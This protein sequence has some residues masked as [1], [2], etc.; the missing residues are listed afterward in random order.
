MGA[1]IV[2]ITPV[3]HVIAEVAIINQITH[4]YSKERSKSKSPT[5]LLTYQ[6]TYRGLIS[7]C[8]FSE[9]EAK[10][11]EANYHELYE[12]SDQW[13]QDKLHQ[14]EKDG[15]VTLAF[16]LRLRTPILH[17]TLIGSTYTPFQAEKEA[18]TAG[19]AV[20]GQSYGLLNSRAGVDLQERVIASEHRLDIKTC[21]QIHDANYLL[22]R[23][24]LACLKWLNDNLVECVEWQELPEIQ[25]PEVKLTGNLGVFY[26]N[27]SNEIELPHHADYRELRTVCMEGK[28]KYHAKDKH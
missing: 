21:A 28:R 17:K 4:Q 6:G 1:R 19:N 9:F 14:A 25:H 20:S 26:P 18:K 12:V 13:V 22:V 23:N 5:F 27:W 3:T 24:N 16:G 7:N 2:S 11:I 15:Y 10:S 8:G